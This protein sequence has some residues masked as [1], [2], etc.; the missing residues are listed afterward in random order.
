MSHL[1][2][3]CGGCGCDLGED[4]S[5]VYIGGELIAVRCSACMNTAMEAASANMAAMNRPRPSPF[6]PPQLRLVGVGHKLST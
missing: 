5:R 4:I 2:E 1:V 3:I 6:I